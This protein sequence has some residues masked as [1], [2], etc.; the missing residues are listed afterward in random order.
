[1]AVPLFVRPSD[2]AEQRLERAGGKAIAVVS[3][4][5]RL[6]SGRILHAVK[7][8]E[9]RCRVKNLIAVHRCL[10][11]TKSVGWR[12]SKEIPRLRAPS[13]I[14]S[15]QR[16]CIVGLP[17]R[18]VCRF[19]RMLLSMPVV[20]RQNDV[21]FGPANDANPPR[22]PYQNSIPSSSRRPVESLN[23][24]KRSQLWKN[25]QKPW[26]LA[27]ITFIDYSRSKP[28]LRQTHTR[29]LLDLAE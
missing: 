8:L 18:R 3:N 21:A 25:L 22:I 24:R 4:C 5:L 11:V 10:R 13:S 7:T 26:G 27:D 17:A 12:L 19:E 28:E 20:K 14:P 9:L 16:G 6:L 2:C 15:K 1:M 23:R 29:Q